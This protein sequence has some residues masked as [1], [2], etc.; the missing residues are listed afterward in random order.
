MLLWGGSFIA[1]KI[2][3]QDL[4]AVTLVWVRFLIGVVILG[5]Y[6]WRQGE[7]RLN[8]WKDSLQFLYL[9][10]IGITFH[11]WLQ[12]TG[13]E[14]SEA[15]TTAWIVSS[16]PVFMA[17]MGWLLL[18]EKLG[19]Q[20]VSGILLAAAGVV[21]VISRGDFSGFSSGSFGRPGD[22]LISISAPNWALFSV[23]SRPAL[24]R[25]SPIRVTFFVILFGWLLSG[26]PFAASAGWRDFS[27]LSAQGWTSVLYLGVL[28]SSVA[29]IF[30]F[31]GLHHLPASRVGAFLYLEPLFATL[32][33]AVVLSEQIIITTVLGGALILLGV[34]LVEHTAS[35]HD[36]PNPYA[37]D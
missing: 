16:T 29:Y 15:S 9:G 11:Q 10:F 22:L 4:S 3:L 18:R 19:W 26:I 12:S 23:L 8:S 17:M 24:R 13:L 33:A 36:Q 1:T 14:T 32:I 25:H 2:A 21:L 5:W 28:C 20:T 35:R 6:A 37:P 27:S 30:Y 7:L 34:W 31:D